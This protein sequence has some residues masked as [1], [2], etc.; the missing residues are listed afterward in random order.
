[1][2]RT[3]AYWRDLLGLPLVYTQGGPGNRQYFFALPDG[4]FIVF[5]EFSG[6]TPQPYHHHGAPQAGAHVFD[7]L[8]IA[9]AGEEDLWEMLA[10]L[11]AA[12]MPVSDVIDHGMVRSIYTFDPNGIPVEFLLPTAGVDVAAEPKFTEKE[13]TASAVEGPWPVRGRWPEPVPIPPDERRAI[14][15]EGHENFADLGK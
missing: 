8:A 5:F 9:V 14:A 13:P 6:A 11:E 10:L 2:D 12:G 3:V 4:S 1:M 7:H 15:G